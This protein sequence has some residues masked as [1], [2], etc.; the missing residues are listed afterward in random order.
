MTFF[1]RKLTKMDAL[2]VILALAVLAALS[3][4]GERVVSRLVFESHLRSEIFRICQH[5]CEQRQRLVAAISAYKESLGF[6][7]PDHLIRKDPVVVDPVTN[8]LFYELYGTVYD[9][10]TR[11]FTPFNSSTH[12]PAA[13]VREY[14][15]TDRFKNSAATTEAVKHFLPETETL[16]EVHERPETIGL[17]SF[18]P[19][20]EGANWDAIAKMRFGSWQY[21]SSKPAHNPGGFDLWIEIQAPGT[22]IVIGNW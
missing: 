10:S 21:N 5:A 14:F 9:P 3:Y 22:N 11:S 19:N 20:W 4:A 8:Q 6:Y 17:L 7:P 1:K 18:S 15:N 16:V 13:L 2:A 12:L